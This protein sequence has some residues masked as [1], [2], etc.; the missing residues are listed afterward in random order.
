MGRSN[1]AENGRLQYESGQL[2]KVMELM[3]DSGDQKKFTSS[4]V[5]WS[6]KSGYEAVVRPDG[7][8]TGGAMVPTSGQNDKVDI[9]AL[10]CNLAGVIASVG[11]AAATAV[12]RPA[13]NVAKV[14]S[15]TVNSSAAIAVVAGTDGASQVFSETRGAAGGPPLIPVGSIEIGQVRLTTSAPAVVVVSE[16]FQ[17]P[18]THQ[19]RYDYPVWEESNLAGSITFTDALTKIH[20]GVLAKKVYCQFYTPIFAEVTLS[21]DFQAPEESYTTS[22]E[23]VYGSVL[24][25]ASKSLGQ[26]KFSVKLADGITENIV[27]LSGSILWFKFNPDRL[28]APY[29]LCQGKLGVVRSFPVADFIKADCVIAASEKSANYAS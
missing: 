6:G 10:S 15:I 22:S 25:K 14:N 3:T 7:L 26:G 9:A 24:G 27:S 1:T 4:A 19:E 23:Q 29:L 2:Y 28:K 8:I 12:T 13:T 20:T 21:S 11:A 18:G 17:V 16:I 5:P